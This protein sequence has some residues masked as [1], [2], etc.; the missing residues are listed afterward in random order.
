MNGRKDEFV[1]IKTSFNWADEIDFNGFRLMKAADWKNFKAAVEKATFPK[2]VYF[3]S[4]E[5]TEY[6]DAKEYL[7]NFS[8]NCTI[9]EE[10]FTTIAT[11]LGAT[12]YELKH[13]SFNIGKDG[14][15]ELE[16]EDQD[17]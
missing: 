5:E 16:E 11:C 13:K 10:E 4:N 6:Q 9:S 17:V 3:G 12:E 15:I 7:K 2:T 1:V 8:I 14:H